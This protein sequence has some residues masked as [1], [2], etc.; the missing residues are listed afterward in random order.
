MHEQHIRQTRANDGRL[1]PTG[2]YYHYDGSSHFVTY[3]ESHAD[4]AWQVQDPDS[5]F[6]GQLVLVGEDWQF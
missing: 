5:R 6:D 1:L 3:S 2:I 4:G